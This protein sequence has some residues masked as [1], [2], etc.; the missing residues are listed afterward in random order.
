VF[1]IPGK[2]TV[3]EGQ[4]IRRRDRE[5]REDKERKKREHSRQRRQI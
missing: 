5:V 2:N 3:F 4:E 1:S